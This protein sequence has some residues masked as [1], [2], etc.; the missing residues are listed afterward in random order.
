LYPKEE[1]YRLIHRLKSKP[2][3][4]GFLQLIS[5][6]TSNSASYTLFLNDLF[7]VYQSQTSFFIVS[8]QKYF[9]EPQCLS[10]F[11]MDKNGFFNKTQILKPWNLK[12]KKANPELYNNI[13]SAIKNKE[14]KP[15]VDCLVL[16]DSIAERNK[17]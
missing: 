12:L 7:Q 2:K 5:F 3:Y 6:R 11:L 8:F 13:Q 15:F 14:N 1:N 10:S 17:N 16:K 4:S 9:K